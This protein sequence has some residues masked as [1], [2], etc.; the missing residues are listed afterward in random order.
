MPTVRLTIP[1]GYRLTQIADRVEEEL[2]IPAKTFLAQATSGD[3]SLPPYLPK[4]TET[5]E[6]FLFPETYRSAGTPTADDVIQRLL[7]QFEHRGRGLAWGN[8]KELGVTPYEVVTDRLDDRAGG[9]GRRRT[10][11]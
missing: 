6:G 8:A 5:V 1:E 2:G 7:D 10:G 11:R 9:R 3:W 4:G